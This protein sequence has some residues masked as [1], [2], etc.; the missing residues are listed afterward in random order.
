MP[1]GWGAWQKVFRLGGPPPPTGGRQ[2][3]PNFGPGP[4]WLRKALS[5][6]R[7][8]WAAPHQVLGLVRPRNTIPNKGEWPPRRALGPQPPP[9]FG[10][11]A[12]FQVLR[13]W[14]CPKREGPPPSP[15]SCSIPRGYRASNY[16]W[17]SC[18]KSR[19]APLFCFHSS[20]IPPFSLPPST[21]SCFPAF[22]PPD[23]P[24]FG[25]MP[26]A[27][28]NP[29]PRNGKPP[30]VPP[31]PPPGGKSLGPFPPCLMA[32]PQVPPIGGRPPANHP[33]DFFFPFFF[34]FY[35]LFFLTNFFPHLSCIFYSFFMIF[36]FFPYFVVFFP[37][38]RMKGTPPGR[39]APPLI[40]SPPFFL[41]TLFFPFFFFPPPSNIQIIP[42]S[43]PAGRDKLSL[44][45]GFPG[46]PPRALFFVF[47][48][49]PKPPMPPW[50]FVFF[51]R[52]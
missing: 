13:W 29:P 7:P 42:F 19:P 25:S 16:F 39:R 47:F 3:A 5:Q 28:P 10:R 45:A 2:R 26:A 8:W 40:F 22:S 14:G 12:R 33:L 32:P 31:P 1:Q 34:I 50:F 43:S 11:A 49:T 23:P 4:E 24:L 9:Y 46:S 38:P 35:I 18:P 20:R 27:P 21:L 52:K 17:F 37:L 15:F 6:S 51:A 41:F 30:L 48:T 36:F 44:L